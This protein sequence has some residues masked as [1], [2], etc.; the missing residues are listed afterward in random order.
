MN[1]PCATK[2][3]ICNKISMLCFRL[4]CM[5]QAVKVH[6][7]LLGSINIPILVALN[8][9]WP[10]RV[11]LK[12]TRW[13]CYGTKKVFNHFVSFTFHFHVWINTEESLL[14]VN[15]MLRLQF[16]IPCSAHNFSM[17]TSVCF[18]LFPYCII[19]QNTPCTRKFRNWIANSNWIL[20][21][22]VM[23]LSCKRKSMR[24]YNI[25]TL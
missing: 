22:V 23:H 5:F 9:H 15:A 3:L 1:R 17:L 7:H 2:N 6:H 24:W 18:F 4:L 13:R 19:I 14:P 16:W 20:C 21:S 8:L 10:I 25:F 12:L 11:S